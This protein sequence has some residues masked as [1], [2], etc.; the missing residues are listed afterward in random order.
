MPLNRETAIQQINSYISRKSGVNY[1]VVRTLQ[2]GI[3]KNYNNKLDANVI[4]ELLNEVKQEAI[5]I[6]STASISA[7]THTVMHAEVPTVTSSKSYKTDM[8]IN[9]KLLPDNVTTYVDH[10]CGSGSI[11]MEIAE[12]LGVQTSNIT[13]VDIYVHDDVKFPIVVPNEHT[14]VINIPTE[15]TDFLTAL[16]SLHHVGDKMLPYVDSSVTIE[17]QDVIIG[18]KVNAQLATINEIARILKPGGSVIIYEHDVDMKDTWMKLFLDA[19]HMTFML[20]GTENENSMGENV[21]EKI[22]LSDV[23]WIVED[24]VYRTK[25]T[26]RNLFALCGL[27]HVGTYATRNAQNMYFDKF[28]KTVNE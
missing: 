16:L 28:V 6:A 10:G 17:P 12:V 3:L 19:V 5:K 25:L 26:W 13:G 15:S 2:I 1:N 18:T 20:F 21:R 7:S 8:L 27:T 23:K 14:G 9:S 24:T 4:I 22:T 11:S